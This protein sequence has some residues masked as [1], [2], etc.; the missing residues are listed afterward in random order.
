MGLFTKKPKIKI[1]MVGG[2][3]CGKSTVLASM[4]NNA[5][6]TLSGTNLTL[7]A[8]N[9]MIN[10]LQDTVDLSQSYFDAPDMESFVTVSDDN[11]SFSLDSFD[12]SLD[13]AGKKT[14]IS[15]QFVDVPGEF[16]AKPDDF[17]AVK[18]EIRESHVIIFAIDT[19]CLME[20][21]K[22]DQD[23]N[24]MYGERHISNNKPSHITHFIKDELKVEDIEDRLILFVPIKC[25]KYYY[26]GEMPQ[27][28]EAVK[29]G[30]GELLQYLASPNLAGHCTAAVLPIISLGG[31]EFFGFKNND[32]SPTASQEYI[33]HANNG[34]LAEYRPLYCDQPLLYSLAYI[35]KTQDSHRTGP[36]WALRSLLFGTPDGKALSK[37]LQPLVE[38]INRDA[39]KGFVLLQNPLQL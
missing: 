4:W 1:F 2:R 32:I 7:T 27:V 22:E 26:R 21:M 38:K 35:L 23:G 19:P 29:K 14:G 25:E 33:Y 11:A 10:K 31:L 6:A 17:D 28:V 9:V 39:E 18:E 16:F 8:G 12:F 24:P 13:L 34:N 3:R 36:I 37:E 20:D 15:L 5:D 30:Y